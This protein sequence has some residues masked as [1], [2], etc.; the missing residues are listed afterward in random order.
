MTDFGRDRTE[1]DEDR[2]PWLEAVEDEDGEEGVSVA[3]LIAGVVAALVAIGLIVGGVFWLRNRPETVTGSGK[4]IEAQE[5]DYKI[6]PDD[7]GGM[8]VA[9][10]GDTA[11]AASQGAELN[12]A[13]DLGAMP[14]APVATVKA[15]TPA[16]PKATLKEDAKVTAAKPVTTVKL[17]PSTAAQAPQPAP[18]A[19]PLPPKPAAP[20]PKLA[21]AVPP[22]PVPKAPA[23]PELATAKV[24]PSTAVSAGGG[25]GGQVQLGAFSSEAAANKAWASLS[26]RFGFLGGLGK[27]VTQVKTDSGTLYRLRA[28]A[29]SSSAA[30]TL[31]SK[32]RVAGESCS[33]VN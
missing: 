31:C 28:S 26:G 15:P 25:G 17:P 21:E 19:K 1:A 5:G 18:V 13:I 2:L 30:S 29:G 3:R 10:E 12:A 9:G 32:L 27:S 14:E 23:K 16:L 11:Y 20:V 6:K 4:L 24:A 33:V 7:A 8:N 22:K